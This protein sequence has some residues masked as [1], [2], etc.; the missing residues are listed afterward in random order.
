LGG[1]FVKYYI[2]IS[3]SKVD[4]L[5]PQIPTEV[6]KKIATEFKIDF[7]I[8]SASRKA[9]SEIVAENRVTR[10][11]AVCDFIQE[12]GNV[13][14]VAQ[15]DEYIFDA[16]H[17]R[18]GVT[19]E[20]NFVY[21][22]GHKEYTTVVLGGS[23]KHLVGAEEYPPG[24]CN[25][26]H[27]SSLPRILE[28]VGTILK[29]NGIEKSNDT[30]HLL[31]YITGFSS[32]IDSPRQRF[33]FLAK[34]LF[35]DSNAGGSNIPVLIGSP[36]YV[37]LAIDSH[38][39]P[40]NLDRLKNVREWRNPIITISAHPEW[41]PN[42]RVRSTL[43]APSAPQDFDINDLDGDMRE[44]LTELPPSAWPDGRVVAVIEPNLNYKTLPS[45]VASFYREVIDHRKNNLKSLLDT[46]GIEIVWRKA[47]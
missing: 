32:L 23:S 35:Y 42:D 3:D 9:E 10:L 47:E 20:Q 26:K 6:K 45:D 19:D 24:T 15:P 25:Y 40:P 17:L 30:I 7:K 36:L 5:L 41:Y 11:E 34:S 33:E 43:T 44:M 4:M 29:G 18:M 12:F 14:S 28:Y 22:C 2:Y 27:N 38:I 31:K 8:L 1:T 39:Q 13:G 46:I 16:I 37:A 21:F